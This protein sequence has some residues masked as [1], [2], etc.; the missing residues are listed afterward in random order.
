MATYSTKTPLQELPWQEHIRL[1]PGMYVGSENTSGFINL[2]KGFFTDFLALTQSTHLQFLFQEKKSAIIKFRNIS[3]KI[4][5]NFFV[6]NKNSKSHRQ[7]ESCVLNV[8][9][10]NF[11]IKYLQGNSE[12]IKKQ[13]FENG[14]LTNGEITNQ[15]FICQTIEVKFKLD[16]NI[17]REDFKWN[18]HFISHEIKDFAYLYKKTKFEI[19][20]HQDDEP[21]KIIYHFK[22]G[23][24][25]R[26]DLEVMRGMGGSYFETYIDEVFE[27]FSLELAFAFRKYIVDEAFIISFVNDFYTQENGTHVDGVL[28]GL[29]YGVM[30]YFQKHQ[31]T[32]D[33]KISEKGMKENLLLAV[34]VKLE[35][36]LFSGCVRTKLANSEIIEPIAKRISEILFNKIEKN[37]TSSKQ[38]IHKFK[39]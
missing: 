32:N 6:L 26:I 13:Q 36:P 35:S 33:Y 19:Q 1:R 4:S 15:S 39:I 23:L 20:Y 24:K 12:I 17:W 37:E 29:T 5:D 21:C 14:Y 3:Q 38:I 30:K 25:D 22:N 10:K 34:N 27:G 8:L 18:L 11:S 7:L 2:L 31:L 9:S 16:E 28:K